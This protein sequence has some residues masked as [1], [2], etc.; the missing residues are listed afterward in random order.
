MSKEFENENDGEFTVTLSLD[1]GE[2]LECAVITIFEAG[3][4]DYIALLPLE[5]EEADEG[6]VFLYRYSETD[7]GE[8]VLDNIE[9]DEEYDIVSD[10][11]DE[12]LDSQEF[13]ELVDADDEE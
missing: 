9:S 1:N 5:G 4:N 13:D 8:P 11:F 10:A 3:D 6:E 7:N 2:E 12:F